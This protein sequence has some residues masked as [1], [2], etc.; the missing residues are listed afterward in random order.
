MSNSFLRIVGTMIV[1][2]GLIAGSFGVTMAQGIDTSGGSGGNASSEG[3]NNNGTINQ[4]NDQEQN[5]DAEQGQDV[6]QDNDQDLNQGNSLTGNGAEADGDESDAGDG[7]G[8]TAGDDSADCAVGDSSVGDSATGDSNQANAGEQ[9]AGNSNGQTLE[10]NGGNQAN[11]PEANLDQSAGNEAN[12]GDGG[13]ADNTGSI[14]VSF[15]LTLTLIRILNSIL[16]GGD[17]IIGG[18]DDNGVVDDDDD[19]MGNGGGMVPDP[20][21]NLALDC[22]FRMM[23]AGNVSSGDCTI[24]GESQ[25]LPASACGLQGSGTGATLVVGQQLMCAEFDGCEITAITP[26]NDPDDDE[27]VTVQCTDVA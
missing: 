6:D 19:D 9:N 17:T 18:D 8:V 1:A 15:E 2:F 20:N 24:D 11:A 12:A 16:S 13:D 7:G 10:Q 22:E 23:S 14:N 25:T 21:D 3:G 26:G 27:D 4:D 5:Q